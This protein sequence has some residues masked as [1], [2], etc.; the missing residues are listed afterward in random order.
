[1]QVSSSTS[2][3][4]SEEVGIVG[5]VQKNDDRI[6]YT[7]CAQCKQ[8]VVMHSLMK[9]VAAPFL[10]RALFLRQS[11]MPS[12]ISCVFASRRIK[13]RLRARFRCVVCMSVASFFP[14]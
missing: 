13:W 12:P 1:M 10:Y 5:K 3:Y 6:N 4:I 7:A 2:C 8:C 9:G 14:S 11:V